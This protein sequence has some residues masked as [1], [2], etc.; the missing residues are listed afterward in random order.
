MA[1]KRIYQY[2]AYAILGL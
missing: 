2:I 1:R